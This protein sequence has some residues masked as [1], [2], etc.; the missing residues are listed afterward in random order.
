M[1]TNE[2]RHATIAQLEQ[3]LL[4]AI[5]LLHS[6]NRDTGLAAE[7]HA[8]METVN[9]YLFKAYHALMNLDAVS[10]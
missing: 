6:L 1:T 3:T 10:A 8:D 4:D 5:D 9:D 2:A 7:A